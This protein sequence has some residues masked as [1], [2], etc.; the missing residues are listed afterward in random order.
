M[1][2]AAPWA[3]WGLLLLAGPVLVHLLSRRTATRRRFPTLRFLAAARLQPVSRRTLDDRALLALRL[4]IVALAVLAW[5]RPQRDVPSSAGGRTAINDAMVLLVDTSASMQRTS[6]VGTAA[7]VQARLWADSAVVGVARVLRVE[8]ATPAAAVQPAAEWLHDAGGGTLV[9]LTDAQRGSVTPSDV[10]GLPS[11]V[12]LVVRPIAL[13]RNDTRTLRSG[14]DSAVGGA[15]AVYPAQRLRDSVAP[16]FDADRD[17]IEAALVLALADLAA[18]PLLQEVLMRHPVAPVERAPDDRRG[19]IAVPAAPHIDAAVV[20]WIRPSRPVVLQLAIDAAHPVA[21]VLVAITQE[22]LRDAAD[23]PL[24][25]RDTA[26]LDA[27]QLMALER[28]ASERVR[29]AP[30]PLGLDDADT[31]SRSRVLWMLVLLAL[32][33]EWWLR[34]RIARVGTPVRAPDA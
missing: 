28:D 8:T 18:H 9:L 29:A 3:L 14:F 30:A 16:A 32:G 27:A 2:L 7:V 17:T 31:S 20:G 21:Q 24:H 13:Q 22:T 12:R 25:E 10:Q 33:G 1:R 4:L 6:L 15:L 19:W 26:I 11:S 5:A 23:V 34:T